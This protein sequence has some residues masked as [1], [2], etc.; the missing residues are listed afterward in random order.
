[1]HVYTSLQNTKGNASHKLH[2]K[3]TVT[4]SLVE[5]IIYILCKHATVAFNKEEKYRLLLK[6]SKIS[7]PTILRIGFGWLPGRG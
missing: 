3:H 7:G 2:A 4:F 1:M 5:Y 6:L